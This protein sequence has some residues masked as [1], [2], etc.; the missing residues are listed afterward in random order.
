MVKITTSGKEKD[1]K[2]RATN[3]KLVSENLK[4][5]GQIE[6]LMSR[7][8]ALEASGPI[9]VEREVTANVT[10]ANKFDAL[11]EDEGVAKDSQEAQPNDGKDKTP[12][13]GSGNKQTEHRPVAQMPYNRRQEELQ[14]AK[15]WQQKQGHN[16]RSQW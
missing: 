2:I 1:M 6:K 16:C 3:K 5:K 11:T 12:A 15:E 14:M 9:N 10:T 8:E 7:V 4:L 13:Q